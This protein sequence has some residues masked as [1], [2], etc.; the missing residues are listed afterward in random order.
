MR[1]A[2]LM[3]WGGI[4]QNCDA[5]CGGRP[6]GANRWFDFRD[7]SVWTRSSLW[8][9]CRDSH[10]MLQKHLKTESKSLELCL[11]VWRCCFFVCSW[12]YLH[13]C[14]FFS[15]SSEHSQEYR[16]VFNDYQ[17]FTACDVIQ[18]TVKW[19]RQ[20]KKLSSIAPLSSLDLSSWVGPY[21]ALSTINPPASL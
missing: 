8:Y 20:L 21:N 7:D 19:T 1:K 17:Q 9:L 4:R 15:F 6:A 2:C 14:S 16:G 3:F 18:Y 5:W 11:M 10:G 12:P 13:V